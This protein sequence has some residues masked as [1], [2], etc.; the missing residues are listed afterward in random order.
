M[1]AFFIHVSTIWLLI[2]AT[3]HDA[4]TTM[5]DSRYS[6]LRF[7]SLCS[8]KCQLSVKM[9]ILEQGLLY[10]HLLGPWRCKKK[11]NN[12]S[13]WTVML[14]F[15]KFPV[16]GRLDGPW[17]VP[18]PLSSYLRLTVCFF[19]KLEQRFNYS[20]LVLT[21][22]CLNWWS[23]SSCWKLAPLSIW[24]DLPKVLNW[25]LFKSC[26]LWPTNLNEMCLN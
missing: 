5:L 20:V 13:L 14:L 19:Q 4:T 26:A 16:K 12:S 21:Y 18:E 17:V 23:Q 25:T 9:S 1:S 11:K 22:S 7:E 2:W 15:Q 8:C 6:I 10:R 24:N 3:E